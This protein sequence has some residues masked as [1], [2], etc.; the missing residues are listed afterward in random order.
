MKLTH[1]QIYPG[2][3]HQPPLPKRASEAVMDTAY[4]YLRNACYVFFF[5]MN[6]KYLSLG[7][8][9]LATLLHAQKWYCLSAESAEQ[10]AS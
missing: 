4:S 8:L 7:S 3:K 9:F 10:R 1:I 6:N 5:N 2:E